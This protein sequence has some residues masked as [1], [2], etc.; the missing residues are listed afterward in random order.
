MTLVPKG[1]HSTTT[2]WNPPQSCY[3]SPLKHWSSRSAAQP[4]FPHLT[5]LM[6]PRP[7]PGLT[8]IPVQSLAQS[9]CS[10]NLV[11]DPICTPRGLEVGQEDP[12]PSSLPKLTPAYSPSALLPPAFSG[13]PQVG[14]ALIPAPLAS[15]TM[16]TSCTGKGR[17]KCALTL[18]VARS[19]IYPTTCGGT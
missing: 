17:P 11:F 9:R 10:V 1:Q 12:L 2:P 19:S 8:D 4:L 13:A 15:R 18:A 7:F 5:D 3:S 14:P 16:S 6:V